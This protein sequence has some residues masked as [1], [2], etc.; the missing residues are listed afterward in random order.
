MC[1]SQ[2]WLDYLVAMGVSKA[3]PGCGLHIS[4]AFRYAESD[5]SCYHNPQIMIAAFA[6]EAFSESKIEVVRC[7]SQALVSFRCAIRRVHK[8]VYHMLDV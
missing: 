8:Q 6:L 2:I 5:F 4:C 3:R 1:K 7:Y